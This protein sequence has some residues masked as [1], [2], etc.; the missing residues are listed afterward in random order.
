MGV[1]CE[2]CGVSNESKVRRE[3]NG[4]IELASQVILFR[5]L[6]S[7]HRRLGMVASICDFT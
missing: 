4:D 6:K 3:E 2:K 5:F 7:L 1:I